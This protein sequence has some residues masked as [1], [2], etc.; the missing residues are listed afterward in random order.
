MKELIAKRYV[1]AFYKV[2]TQEELNEA[3]NIF[4]KLANAY[5]IIKFQEIIKS[6]YI[7]TEKKVDFI[8]QD[9]LENK[10]SVKII[11]FIKILAEHNRLDLFPE[12]YKET[13]SYVASLKKE[14]IAF[15]MVNEDYGESRVRDFESKFSKK[16]GVNLLLEQKIVQEVGIKLVVEDLG[17]EISFSQDKFINDLKNHILRAF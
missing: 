1:K 12:L 13:S 10:I 8:I 3:I 6:P 17:I 16:L 9:V 14:Y 11:N 2:A 15:L 4:A 7:V 5:D